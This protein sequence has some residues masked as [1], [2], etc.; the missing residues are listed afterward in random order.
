MKWTHVFLALVALMALTLGP[1]LAQM[2]RPGMESAPQE[3]MA[4]MMTMMGE[5]QTMMEHHREQM[6]AQC[7]S[8]QAPTPRSGG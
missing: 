1:A 4:R 8:L 2:S 6:R 7:P 3:P 5:M